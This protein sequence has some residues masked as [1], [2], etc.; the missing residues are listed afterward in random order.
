MSPSPCSHVSPCSHG[1]FVG[2]VLGWALRSGMA[3]ARTGFKGLGA[4]NSIPCRGDTYRVR[5]IGGVGSGD[6]TAGFRKGVEGDSEDD[7]DSDNDLLDVGGDVHE[8]ETVEQNA[9]EDR[10]DDRAEDRADAAE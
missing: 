4:L 7:D 9:D 5:G 2:L 1:P 8:H 10:A 6:P 3:R